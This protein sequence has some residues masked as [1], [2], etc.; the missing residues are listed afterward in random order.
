[1]IRLHQA[2]IQRLRRNQDRLPQLLVATKR[3]FFG[4]QVKAP[5]PEKLPE[6][7]WI[8]EEMRHMTLLFLG[9]CEA[10][11]LLE[12]LVEMPLPHFSLGG[13]GI[14]EKL[15][16]LPSDHP[17][18]AA[19]SVRWLKGEGD[20]LIYRKRL[21]DWLK[22]IGYTVQDSFLPHISLARRP[23]DPAEWEAAFYPLPFLIDAF[24]LYE[25]L[26]DLQ[27][28][29]LWRFPLLSAFE[30]IEHTADVAFLVRGESLQELHLHAMLALSFQFPPFL[31]FF[32]SPLLNSLAEIIMALN[33]MVLRADIALGC[34]IKA[35]SFHGDIHKD[36]NGLLHWEM[37]IDV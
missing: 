16:F 22:G 12:N 1:M 14:Q 18:V 20:L 28:A 4:A 34:P 35:V 17:R 37:I 7:R 30:E 25:S 26:G 24:C 5:W 21:L 19:S 33:D 2:V 6:G 23:F 13:S 15:L 8:T 10:D 27:Y 11:L 29:P 32:T 31:S 3:L 36:E 9:N